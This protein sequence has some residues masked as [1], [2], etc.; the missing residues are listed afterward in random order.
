MKEMLIEIVKSLKQLLAELKNELK[1]ISR[2]IVKTH[3]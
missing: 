2:W 1:D 3:K